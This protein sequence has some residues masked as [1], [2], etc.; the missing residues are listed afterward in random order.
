MLGTGKLNP[1]STRLHRCIWIWKG[2]FVAGAFSVDDVKYVRK[3][4]SFFLAINKKKTYFIE[5]KGSCV[6]FPKY[7]HEDIRRECYTC[8]VSERNK[9]KLYLKCKLAPIR[10]FNATYRT[11]G[12]TK[13]DFHNCLIFPMMKCCSILLLRVLY[14]LFKA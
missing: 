4:I 6:R 10:L 12:C 11:T 14:I 9:V 1:H 8:L 5:I 7:N 2:T 3:I 13:A